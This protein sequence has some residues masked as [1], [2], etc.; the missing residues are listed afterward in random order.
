VISPLMQFEE[1]QTISTLPSNQFSLPSSFTPETP[2]KKLMLSHSL[3]NPPNKTLPISPPASSQTLKH[4]HK[5]IQPT[6]PHGHP[7][8]HHKPFPLLRCHTNIPA[9]SINHMC[10]FDR[11]RS[12][13]CRREEGSKESESP[14][15][16]ID[17]CGESAV[18]EERKEGEGC[19]ED[20]QAGRDAI[21]KE[22]GFLCEAQSVDA[23]V[24]CIR[25]MQIFQ[26]HPRVR[27]IQFHLQ[28]NR[29]IEMEK[30]SPVTASSNI[31]PD[32]G[33]REG[34]V[35]KGSRCIKPLTVVQKMRRVKVM[36]PQSLCERIYI[37]IERGFDG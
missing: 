18:D 21:Q 6:Q 24:D 30:R 3:P 5:N 8:E 26:R 25:P 19:G 9:V 37:G 17:E 22:S 20:D 13:D 32:F 35:G 2:K 12:R 11:N 14:E 1:P 31:S 34:S 23:R 7:R 10:C 29:R 4:P 16:N 15:K 27:F 36:Q 28:R 33:R